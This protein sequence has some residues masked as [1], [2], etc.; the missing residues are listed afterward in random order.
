[1]KVTW[2]FHATCLLLRRALHLVG[3]KGLTKVKHK[4]Q[5]N[6]ALQFQLQLT[7]TSLGGVT[8]PCLKHKKCIHWWF[9]PK[10]FDF[11]LKVGGGQRFFIS[12]QLAGLL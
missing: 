7:F 11:S 8:H 4:M 3:Q 5:I 6:I 2:T 12:D 9:L 1:M 10:M